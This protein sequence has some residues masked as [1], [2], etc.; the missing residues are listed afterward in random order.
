MKKRFWRYFLWLIVIVA[1]FTLVDLILHY[2]IEYLE[3]YYY[4]IPNFL[5][6]ISDSPLIWY[7]I[8]KFIGS[9]IIGLLCYPLIIRLKSN[10]TKSLTLTIITILLLEARYMISGYYTISWD[11]FNA[12]NHFVVLFISSYF[13]FSKSKILDSKKR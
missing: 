11:L 6:F 8:G 2:S 3:I 13:I 4:P 12:V 10:L 7:G 9:F 1:V 5:K